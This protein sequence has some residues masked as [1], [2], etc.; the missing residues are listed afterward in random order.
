MARIE[1]GAAQTPHRT[2]KGGWFK[3]E[4]GGKGRLGT[5]FHAGMELEV[6]SAGKGKDVGKF[7]N[8]NHGVGL[9]WGSDCESI[10][11]RIV[12]EEG[13]GSW[14]SSGS[15]GKRKARGEPRLCESRICM[16]DYWGCWLP[17][18]AEL[19]EPEAELSLLLPTPRTVELSEPMLVPGALPELSPWHVP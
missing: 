5:D 9:G 6:A 13:E 8:V 10:N 17:W 7:R 11:R 2:P 4:F 18:L 19:L 3:K 1:S 16:S 15:T 14:A 12:I